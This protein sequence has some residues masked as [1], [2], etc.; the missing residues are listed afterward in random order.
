M[1]SYTKYY[2]VYMYHSVLSLYNSIHEVDRPVISSD[3]PDFRI[4]FTN[5]P[6]PK[7]FLERREV[8]TKE[9]KK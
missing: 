6:L 5:L 4:F 2:H 7:N 3:F 9:R 8:A 1:K